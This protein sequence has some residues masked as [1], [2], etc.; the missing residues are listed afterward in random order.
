VSNILSGDDFVNP[1]KILERRYIYFS[2]IAINFRSFRIQ[3]P[4]ADTDALYEQ[5]VEILERKTLDQMSN[6]KLRLELQNALHQQVL[7]LFKSFQRVDQKLSL[8]NI[9]FGAGDQNPLDDVDW[10]LVLSILEKEHSS[11]SELST[12]S[13]FFDTKR[14][15]LDTLLTFHLSEDATATDN[16]AFGNDTSAMSSTSL[17][18]MRRYQSLNM[19]RSALIRDEIGHSILSLRSTIPSC[20]RGVFVDGNTL[21]GSLIAFQPGDVWPKEHLL[22]TAPDVIEHFANDDDCHISLRFDDYVVDSR[23]APVTVLLREGS[24]NPWA[25]GHM[26]NHPPPKAPPTCQSTMLNYTERMELDNASLSQYI[27]NTYA[28]EPGWKSRIFYSEPMSMHG[29]CLI[30]KVD[31]GNQEL[32]YDYRLQSEETPAW[33]TVAESGIMDDEQ[34][35][36]FRDDWIDKK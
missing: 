20:G 30:T 10:K 16:D 4:Q 13:A 1:K 26:I 21:A 2:L 29:L 19:A 6:D 27:P 12:V 25:L 31:V 7:D 11:L 22:T 15:A 17:K 36:F 3:N 24:T 5:T 8:D 23:N 33:Y 28:R 14:E 18:L 34:V 9:D 32:F 35:V